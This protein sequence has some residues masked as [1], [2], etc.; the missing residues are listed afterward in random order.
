LLSF[1]S[2]EKEL[3]LIST[4]HRYGKRVFTVLLEVF[5]LRNPGEEPSF[6][7]GFLMK[8]SPGRGFPLLY[9]NE[10]NLTNSFFSP[11]WSIP[12]PNFLNPRPINLLVSASPEK[13]E[14]EKYFLELDF[15][16]SDWL[17]FL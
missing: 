5:N 12:L 7:P 17:G 16:T 8:L 9:T 1:P 2:G 11:A 10:S 3:L 4:E 14:L 15:A 6:L 13:K